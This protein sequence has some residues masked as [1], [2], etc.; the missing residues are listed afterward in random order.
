MVVFMPVVMIV[1]HAVILPHVPARRG[2][3]PDFLAGCSPPLNPRDLPHNPIP[4]T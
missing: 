2:Y 1:S 3:F 4:L